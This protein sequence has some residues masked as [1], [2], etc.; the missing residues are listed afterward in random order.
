MT[1]VTSPT[2]PPLRSAISFSVSRQRPVEVEQVGDLLAAGHL[3]H[4]DAGAG[5]EHRAA[6]GEGDHGQGA[7]HAAGAE[8]RPLER[9]DGDVDLT[10]G[11]P[12]PICSPLKSIGAS[13]FSPSPITTTPSIETESS[14]KRIAS[15]AAPVGGDLVAAADPAGGGERGGLGDAHQLQREV[16]IG[17]GRESSPPS[18]PQAIGSRAWISDGD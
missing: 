3:F 18:G 9:V 11:L 17:L 4:V 14:T 8:R 12:S 2:S 5:V 15:T 13:S 7:G 1:T 6:L 10:G 16:A